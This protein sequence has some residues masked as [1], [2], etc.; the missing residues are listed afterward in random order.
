MQMI[1]DFS[2][3]SLSKTIN[4]DAKKRKRKQYTTQKNCIFKLLI[5]ISF[6]VCFS[7]IHASM[8]VAL[9]AASITVHFEKP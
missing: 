4:M 6:S 9:L 8:A 7:S 2:K 3:D 1:L 5:S